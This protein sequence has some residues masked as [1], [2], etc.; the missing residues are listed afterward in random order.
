[1]NKD[2]WDKGIEDSA[3]KLIHNTTEKLVA[4]KKRP[5]KKPKNAKILSLTTRLSKQEKNK[6]SVLATV[7]GG[8]GNITHTRTNT[9][10]SYP[11]K[12]YVEVLNNLE[13]CRV[14]KSKDNITRDGQDWYW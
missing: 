4:A 10:V 11:N 1:M 7:K 6:N 14:N 12:S 8:G 3:V 2:Y 13:S 9:K 5:Q